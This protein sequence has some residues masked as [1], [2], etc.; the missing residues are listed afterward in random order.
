MLVAL[1]VLAR[2]LGVELPPVNKLKVSEDRGSNRFI[3]F[4]IVALS[5]D[6]LEDI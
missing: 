1:L 3:R 4:I 5:H 6:V 2:M